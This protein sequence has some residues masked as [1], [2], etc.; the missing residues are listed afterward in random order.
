MK[1]APSK[2]PAAVELR[3]MQHKPSQGQK[4]K[5]ATLA[6]GENNMVVAGNQ[7]SKPKKVET[8]LV[9]G[10][11]EGITTMANVQDSRPSYLD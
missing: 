4:H 1:P 8:P 2:A 11:E 9:K 5:Q 3:H 10:V 6:K 7:G